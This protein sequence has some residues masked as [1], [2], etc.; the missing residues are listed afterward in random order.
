MK[1]RYKIYIIIIIIGVIVGFLTQEPSK[2][3]EPYLLWSTSNNYQPTLVEITKQ[4]LL[5]SSS[6][7]HINSGIISEQNDTIKIGMKFKAKNTFNGYTINTAYGIFIKT[8][9]GGKL[10]NYECKH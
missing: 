5:N 1:K 2:P 3:K 10:I 4:N 7:I 9:D 6:F 8:V